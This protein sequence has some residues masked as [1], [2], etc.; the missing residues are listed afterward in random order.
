M[1]VD[2]PGGDSLRKSGGRFPE[3]WTVPLRQDGVCLHPGAVAGEPGVG[4]RHQHRPV[5]LHPGI[6][7]GP[8]LTT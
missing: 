2:E 3:I 4:R 5:E 7:E 1:H 8:R 6:E